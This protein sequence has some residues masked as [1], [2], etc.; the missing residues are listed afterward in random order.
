MADSGKTAEKDTEAS[1]AT[2]EQQ[3]VVSR[4]SNLPLV[5]SACGAVYN[6]YSS[7]K[8]SVPLLKGVMEVAES[9]VRTLGAAASTGSRPIL[10]RL[11]PQIAMVNEYAIKGLE[12]TLTP[13]LLEQTRQQIGQV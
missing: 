13:I 8:D 7:T 2:Q 4:V 9:G 5:S 12:K 11:E 1:Q 6:A 10:D 3:S